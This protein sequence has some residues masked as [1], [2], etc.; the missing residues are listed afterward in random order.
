MTKLVKLVDGITVI[1][2]K[3]SDT[4]ASLIVILRFHR[5][6]N[7]ESDYRRI[8]PSK[9]VLQSSFK[10]MLVTL[11]W[12]MFHIFLYPPKSKASLTCAPLL[13]YWTA[14]YVPVDD[15]FPSRFA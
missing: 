5:L 13:Q 9:I 15:I 6:Q 1:H 12:Y 3:F 4:I 7:K 2:L 14:V 11:P 10:S 8:F